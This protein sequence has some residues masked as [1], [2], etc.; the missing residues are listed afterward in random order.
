MNHAF[1]LGAAALAATLALSACQQQTTSTEKAASG[2]AA[3]AS[4]AGLDTPVKQASYA[5][6]ADIGRSLAQMKKNAK[7]QALKF[8]LNNILP[9]YEKM[10]ANTIANFFEKETV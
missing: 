4:P 8:D 7:Q 6:G 3:A 2:T 9:E 1:K 5:I 10:Y